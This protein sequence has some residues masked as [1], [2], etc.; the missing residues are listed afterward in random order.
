[1]IIM[2]SA[3]TFFVLQVID[4]IGSSNSGFIKDYQSNV[5]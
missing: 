4:Y 5:F 3:V 1:M 2:S